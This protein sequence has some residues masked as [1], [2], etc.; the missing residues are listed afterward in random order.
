MAL[1]QG[2][3]VAT[4]PPKTI[5]FTKIADLKPYLKTLNI[6]CIVLEKLGVSKN[7]AGDTITQCL[8]ADQSGSII[9]SLWDDVGDIVK[10]GDILQLRGG[11]CTI[12]K[13]ELK[14]YVGRHGL[15]ERIGEFMLPFSETPNMSKVK[16]VNDP[17][18]S[19]NWVV[20]SEGAAKKQPSARPP[21]PYQTNTRLNT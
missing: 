15:L 1:P 3:L 21:P 20:K 14:L 11:Y 6:L 12:H 5:Q 19:D 18:N 13:G 7:S 9:I 10:T 4:L 8:V 2:K 16:W 17:P